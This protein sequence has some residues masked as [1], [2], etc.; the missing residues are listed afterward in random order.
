MVIDFHTHAFPDAIAERAIA[1]LVEGCG[2]IYEPCTNGT[3]SDLKRKMSDF[4]VD[5]SV[6]QPVV[7]KPSQTKTVNE[8][9]RKITDGRLISFGG[10]HPATDDWK[11]DID[12][13]CSLGL[14]GIKLHPEYQSFTVDTPEMMK[15]YDYALSKGLMLLFH[16]GYDPAFAPPYH[17]S[18]KQFSNIMKQMKGGTIIAAHLG[19]AKMWED[20]E[21]NLAG[22]GIYIDTSMGFEYYPH[23]L[24]LKI[25]DAIGE[26]RVL[27]GSDSPWSRAGQEIE[28]L[29]SLALSQEIKEKI[30]YKNA[31]KLL[32]L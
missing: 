5:I 20:V 8:W 18:P 24:F 23:D 27:F 22:T 13:I 16:A 25:V 11:R 32:K 12:F 21:R 17:S 14:P 28:T 7:T 19:S 9:A 4:G 2:R 29:N 26:D 6:V 10:I 3:A 1:G 31:A 15:I 30:L